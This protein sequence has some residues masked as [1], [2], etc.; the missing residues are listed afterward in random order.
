[1]YKTLQSISK[2]NQRIKI[3]SS[4]RITEEL[5][6]IILS[7]MP[8]KGFILLKETGIL[9]IIFEEMIS[10]VGVET[11]ENFLIKITFIIL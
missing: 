8:S 4:E 5:N 10:L 9:E 7:S 11:I 3:I 2:N 6:K 1:M